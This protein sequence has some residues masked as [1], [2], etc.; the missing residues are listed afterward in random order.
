MNGKA[1]NDHDISS[2][3]ALDSVRAQLDDDIGAEE[4]AVVSAVG[5]EREPPDLV[6]V[7]CQ[8]F[9][10]LNAQSLLPVHTKKQGFGFVEPDLNPRPSRALLAYLLTY[11]LN[12][13]SSRA[14]IHPAACCSVAM[15]SH[16]NWNLVESRGISSS[17]SGCSLRCSHTCMASSTCRFAPRTGMHT[18]ASRLHS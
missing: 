11:L 16:L 2:W 13:R 5:A 9:V 6:V 10:S 14:L 15:L 18:R 3:L 17:Q 7:G 8:E 12:P 4:A 1:C